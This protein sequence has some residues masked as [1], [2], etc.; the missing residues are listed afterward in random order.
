MLV[1]AYDSSSQTALIV[2]SNYNG[3]AGS[4]HIGAHT[5]SFSG[6]SSYAKLGNYRDLDCVY[7]G[8]C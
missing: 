3:G 2:D 8:G 7:T 5:A 4:E 6:T 1:V